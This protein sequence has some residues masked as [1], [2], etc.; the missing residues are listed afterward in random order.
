MICCV[1]VD[2]DF[3]V[4]WR[5]LTGDCWFVVLVCCIDVCS[6]ILFCCWLRFAWACLFVLRVV[7]F[8][9]LFWCLIVL[10]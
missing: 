3:G 2:C 9:L 7:V 8:V 1:L 6:G 4:G 10:V 5:V